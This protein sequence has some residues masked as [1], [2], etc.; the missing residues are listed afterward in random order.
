MHAV[1]IDEN[2]GHEFK[3]KQGKEYGRVSRK[4]RKGKDAAI[5]TLKIKKIIH[6]Q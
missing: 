3:R 2:R 4:E 6:L 5:I 1:K